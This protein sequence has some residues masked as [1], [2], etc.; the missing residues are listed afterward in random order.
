[1]ALALVFSL[2]AAVPPHVAFVLVDDW[3]SYDAAYRQVDLGRTAQLHTP[4][5]DRLTREGARLDS[6]YVQHI[7]SPTRSALLSGRYQIHTG[8]QDGIIQAQAQM[9]LPPAF[10][11]MADAF[12]QLGYAT[13]M[14]GKWHIGV[15]KDACLPWHRGF[16]SYYGYLTGSEHH[17]TKV[18]RIRRGSGNE[19]ALYPDFRTERGPI[20]THCVADPLAP[21]P[22]PP[23]PCGAGSGG[24]PACNYPEAAGYL[25]AGGDVEPPANLTLAA[26]QVRCDANLSCEAITFADDNSTAAGSEPFHVFKVYFKSRVDVTGGAPWRTRFKHPQP[27]TAQGDASCYS[28]HMFTRAATQ[29]VAA[30]DP[31]T[32]FF[33]C[34]ATHALA[35]RQLPTRQPSSCAVVY[36]FPHLQVP[37]AAGG[38]RAHRGARDVRGAVR[39]EHRRPRAPHVRGDGPHDGRGGRQP[40]QRA[41]Q[42]RH[43]EQLGARRLL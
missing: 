12:K 39:A 26:A 14:V 28:T 10:G 15:Y 16:Q 11:T 30:H 37:R 22:P 34:A 4:T 43:V 6:Y 38:A 1:M 20:D 3:G 18:Q 36:P 35:P 8:L 24:P 33:L 2:P 23:P 29:L 5:L 13:H 27:P 25:P 41:R 40:Q 32:P 31:A 9:C 42:P 7:C 17:Y 21:P 19:S